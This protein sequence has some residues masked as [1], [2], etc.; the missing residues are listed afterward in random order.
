MQLHGRVRSVTA[1][2]NP[3]AQSSSHL[4][5]MGVPADDG[6]VWQIVFFTKPHFSDSHLKT[7]T[8]L[9]AKD[10]RS[11]LSSVVKAK[12]GS[13]HP[14]HFQRS[15]GPPDGSA[16]ERNTAVTTHTFINL[17]LAVQQLQTQAAVNEANFI[18]G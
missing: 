9:S 16:I 11:H 8:F 12:I 7:N 18:F 5:S 13:Q 15:E 2:R 17:R 1:Q 14:S 6:K 3:L 10:R 4:L